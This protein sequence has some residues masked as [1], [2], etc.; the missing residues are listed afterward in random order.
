MV[1]TVEAFDAHITELADERG[2]PMYA[3]EQALVGL[4]RTLKLWSELRH[5]YRSRE[6]EQLVARVAFAYWLDAYDLGYVEQANHLLNVF[7]EISP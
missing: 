2:R 4:A 1:M 6:R 7:E 3:H 5:G